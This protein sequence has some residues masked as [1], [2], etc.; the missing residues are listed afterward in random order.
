MRS[1]VAGLARRSRRVTTHPEVFNMLDS[2]IAR[3]A[4]LCLTVATSAFAQDSASCSNCTQA[5]T[6]TP[7]ELA[8]RSSGTVSFIQSRPG[9]QLAENVGFGHGLEGAY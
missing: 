2:R 3:A 6:K 4:F 8:R 5:Q 1:A 7:S 9:G